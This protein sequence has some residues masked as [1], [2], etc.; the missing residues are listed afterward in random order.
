MYIPTGSELLNS[1]KVLEKVGLKAGMTVVDLGCG[2][3]GHFVFPSAKMVG[4]NG[5]VYA[6]DILKSALS[7]IESR[8]KMQ[9]FHNVEAIWSDIEV[10]GATEVPKGSCDAVYLINVHAKQG[11]I[12]EAL[13]LLKKGGKLL[14][15]DWKATATALFGPASAD[16]VSAEEVKKRVK[17]F[18]LNLEEE[19]D[20]GPHHWGLIYRK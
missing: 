9:N 19:F 3:S 7:S 14:L 17:E 12:K 2:T 1:D 10:E 16:R 6:V 20:A 5:K 15:V 8:A 18:N 4:E 13:R 11:M